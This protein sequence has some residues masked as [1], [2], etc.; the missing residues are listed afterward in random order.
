MKF[1][2]LENMEVYGIKFTINEVSFIVHS[3]SVASLTFV[4]ANHISGSVAYCQCDIK[5]WVMSI[6]DYNRHIGGVAINIQ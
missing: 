2:T 6:S 3:K 5:I 1:V 4:S